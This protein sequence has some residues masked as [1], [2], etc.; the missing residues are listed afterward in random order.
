MIKDYI[1]NSTIEDSLV[2]S[3]AVARETRAKK[4][5]LQL[6][7]F[8]GK[9]KIGGNYWDWTTG[10]IPEVNTIVDIVAQVTEYMGAK[11]L[12]IKSIKANTTKH[13]GEFTPSANVDIQ[14][15]Y[16]D[17]FE[18]AS[19]INDDFLKDLCC[20]IY[21]SF[22]DE[23]LKAPGAKSIHHAFIGGTLIHS[24]SVAKIALS[25]SKCINESNNDL[26]IAGALLHD[27]GKVYTYAVNGVSINM[28]NCG[29]LMD[30]TFLSS[31]IVHETAKS[32][33]IYNNKFEKLDLL[34]NIILSHHGKLEYGA[35]VLPMSI[36]A[37]IVSHADGLDASTQQIL[38]KST[39]SMWT[40]KLYTLGGV[41]HISPWYTQQLFRQ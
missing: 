34:M 17:A 39:E 25:I 31:V 22:A 29:M 23:L 16:M 41:P 5:F 27:I 8:D 4:P 1:L 3:S 20:T 6:E 21:T 33:G 37:H 15:S 26:C 11:Q 10:L 40:D 38:E 13:I 24:L 28:T 30:H 2:V 7:L 14:K 9:N 12:N 19:S 32:L 35:A 18:L 36:E